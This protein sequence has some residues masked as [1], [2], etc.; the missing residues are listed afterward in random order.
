[1][2]GA[3]QITLRDGETLAW[4]MPDLYLTASVD[5]CPEPVRSQI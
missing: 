4:N 2:D 3:K 1:M 5:E